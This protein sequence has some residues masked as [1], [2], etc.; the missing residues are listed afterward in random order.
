[1]NPQPYRDY[2]GPQTIVD[3][4]CSGVPVPSVHRQPWQGGPSAGQ[5]SCRRGVP[6]G[7]PR[8]SMIAARGRLRR[9]HTLPKGKG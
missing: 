6:A 1:M 3:V 5:R 9:L 2:S 4:A 8:S 7:L